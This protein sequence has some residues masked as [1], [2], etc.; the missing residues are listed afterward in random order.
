M[1]NDWWLPTALLLQMML[2]AFA[3]YRRLRKAERDN[4]I[5]LVA[6][7]RW[8]IIG[9][10]LLGLGWS[11]W[12]VADLL[13]ILSEAAIISIFIFFFAIGLAALVYGQRRERRHLAP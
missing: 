6:S 9:Y 13:P 3:H 4:Q 10:G 1:S 2:L 11:D 5:P 12:L 8:Q 7:I